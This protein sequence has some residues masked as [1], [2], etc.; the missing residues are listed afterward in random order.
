MAASGWTVASWRPPRKRAS[1]GLGTRLDRQYGRGTG[2]GWTP[3]LTGRRL[4][5]WIV[6][7]SSIAG[8]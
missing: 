6:W 7:H 3:D 4:I 8:D 2:P 1:A 5:R